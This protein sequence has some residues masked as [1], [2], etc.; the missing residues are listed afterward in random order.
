[1]QKG[2]HQCNRIVFST[3]LNSIF[4]VGESPPLYLAAVA[5]SSSEDKQGEAEGGSS[6]G[7][8]PAL[9]L[10]LLLSTTKSKVPSGY[11]IARCCWELTSPWGLP[12]AEWT[13]PGANLRISPEME[14]FQRCCRSKEWEWGNTL[15]LV[16]L[17]NLP[18]MLFVTV[19]LENQKQVS[20]HF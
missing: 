5:A 15:H 8:P 19:A 4:K 3:T 14:A 18:S 20:P 6:G 12:G 11:T 10:P 17:A 16:H 1:M 9:I 2:S 7:S 13:F